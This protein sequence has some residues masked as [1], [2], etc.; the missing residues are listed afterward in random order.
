MDITERLSQVYKSA[1]RISFNDS[2]KFVILSDCHRGD[3]SWADDFAKNQNLFFSALSF[4]FRQDYTY[5]ELGDG[6]ELWENK[7]MTD[8]KAQHG[9]ALWLISEF[10]R[11]RRCYLIYGNHD[12][13][14]RNERFAKSN[15]TTTW[16]ERRRKEICLYGNVTFHEGLILRYRPTG[17]R[18]FL[19]H[20][21]QADFF[22]DSL[23]RL[24]RSLV[25]HLWRPL[26]LVGIHDPFSASKNNKAKNTVDKNLT[27]WVKSERQMLIAGHT[28]RAVFPQPGEAP[29]F[30]DGCCVHPRCITGIE[31]TCGE[32]SLIKWEIKSKEDGTLYI[33]KEILE[34]PVKI[35]E[36]FRAHKAKKAPE[37]P[38]NC[39]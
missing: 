14:K 17:D 1:P 3:G 24:S 7:N 2:A 28:H 8:I 9:D 15:F 10:L 5:I 23:W 35:A 13:M 22:N 39:P 18:I 34:G 36:Y 16:D 11:Q 29:Y 37:K 27:H 12:I 6:D 25:R 21:H 31:I 33:G 20:G 30:N 4:Y 26:E 19:V 38:L 32:I